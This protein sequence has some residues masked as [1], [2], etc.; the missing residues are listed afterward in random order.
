MQF[1]TTRDSTD[2]SCSLIT[3]KY[4]TLNSKALLTYPISLLTLPE[5]NLLGN[6]KILK[7]SSDYLLLTP[8]QY[9]YYY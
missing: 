5:F 9:T 3:D 2:L 6:G 4:S 1:G 8:Y 7:T